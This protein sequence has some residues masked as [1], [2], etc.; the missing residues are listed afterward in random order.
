MKEGS[1]V[2][3]SAAHRRAIAIGEVVLM[4][5]VCCGL[6]LWIGNV[7]TIGAGK[8]L[9]QTLFLNETEVDKILC[10]VVWH[11]ISSASS[12]GEYV[13][14]RV[15]YSYKGLEGEPEIGSQAKVGARV[16][17]SSPSSSLS[18]SLNWC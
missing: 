7:F 8:L 17:F 1:E 4:L 14:L 2:A 9:A 16:S 5:L 15:V 13:C 11:E 12:S 10:R 18:S 3:A 6:V